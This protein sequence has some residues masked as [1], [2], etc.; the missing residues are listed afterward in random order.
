MS[1][2]VIMASKDTVGDDISLALFKY[3]LCLLPF[4]HV[5]L[6]IMPFLCSLIR[7]TSSNALLLFSFVRLFCSIGWTSGLT[8]NTPWSS[9]LYIFNYC[10]YCSFLKSCYDLFGQHLC[11]Y[12]FYCSM[13]GCIGGGNSDQC[14]FFVVCVQH[15]VSKVIT[16]LAL[17]ELF[18]HLFN[19]IVVC[20]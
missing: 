9:Y 17:L 11:K 14:S 20:G 4:A 16:F 7:F 13:K 6:F 5:P 19:F 8:G 18:I 10:R 12:Y 15:E 1:M 2:V 3:L